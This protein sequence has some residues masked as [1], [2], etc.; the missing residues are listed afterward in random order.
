MLDWRLYSTNAKEIGTLYLVFAIF[1]GMIGTGFSVLIRM[2]LSSPGIQFLHGD[3]QLYNVII[4]AH[5]FL[6]IFFMV[7]PGL[8]GGFGK[9]KQIQNKISQFLLNSTSFLDERIYKNNNIT[10]DSTKVSEYEL[11]FKLGAYLAGLIE[12]D[13]TFAIHNKDSKSKKYSPKILVVFNLKDIPLAKKLISV[14]KTGILHN[15]Q[16]QGCVI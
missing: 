7:M 11:K 3:H 12:A 5:A 1:A 9:I 6:M 14:T 8:I 13:G 15:K 4:T 16:Q 10:L 2:E